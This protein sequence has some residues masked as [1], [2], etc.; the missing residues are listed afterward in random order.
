MSTEVLTRQQD[1]TKATGF[2]RAYDGESYF[3]PDSIINS[4]ER[5]TRLFAN[6]KWRPDHFV[7]VARLVNDRSPN[8][9][10]ERS[11]EA[12][13]TEPRPDLLS[14]YRHE[15]EQ[16]AQDVLKYPTGHTSLSKL[17]TAI[18]EDVD[19]RPDQR[20][21]LVVGR[22]AKYLSNFLPH[23]DDTPRVPHYSM[24][25]SEKAT[26]EKIVDIFGKTEDGRSLYETRGWERSWRI[27]K[28]FGLL[29]DELKQVMDHFNTPPQINMFAEFGKLILQIQR[30][31][32]NDGKVTKLNAGEP[33][34][35]TD[36]GET[37]VNAY[38]SSIAHDARYENDDR[39]FYLS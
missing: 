13:N 9:I 2:Y 37:I 30:G 31:R 36:T 18:I 32:L 35:L 29:E 27:A 21:V 15:Y 25:D 33:L 38:L 39:I 5:I 17:C 3:N 19:L 1:F 26:H 10:L 16:V 24:V 11:I 7:A 12:V 8:E 14:V 28:E 6:S 23:S 20:K 4:F 22:A 34:L